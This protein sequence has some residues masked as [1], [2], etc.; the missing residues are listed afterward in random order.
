MSLLI[1][2]SSLFLACGP[3]VDN[4]SGDCTANG[5]GGRSHY[6]SPESGTTYLPDCNNALNRELWRVFA[7]SETSAYIIPRPDGTGLDNGL[8]EADDADLAGLFSQYGLC[9]ENGNP[10]IINDIPP[11]DALAITHALHE[12]LEFTIDADGMISPWAPDDDIIAACEL[13]S[14]TAA[15]DYCKLLE[16]RCSWGSC[17]DIGYIPGAAAVE[18]L[19][20]ALNELYG[21]R[22]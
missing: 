1:L 9:Q 10:S 5:N 7:V 13:T 11:A 20:P 15:I 18:A 2:V 17:E 19:V 4:P 21:I 14:A 22:P 3:G 16:S 8:C 6:H 12:R